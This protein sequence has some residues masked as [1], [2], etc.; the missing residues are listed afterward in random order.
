MITYYN[1]SLIRGALRVA[2]NMSAV[3]VNISEENHQSVFLDLVIGL[4]LLSVVVC[5]VASIASVQVY[6]PEEV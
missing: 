1:T 5:V 4:S 3:V 2:N 6:E